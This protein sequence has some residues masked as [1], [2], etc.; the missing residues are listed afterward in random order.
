MIIISIII[1]INVI[2]HITY[3]S[4]HYTGTYTS[5]KVIKDTTY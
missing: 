3:S 1:N 2:I 4:I 5:Q